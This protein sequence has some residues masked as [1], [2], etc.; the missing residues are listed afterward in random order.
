[1]SKTLRGGTFNLKFGRDPKR[2]LTE[3]GALFDRHR[4]HFL[5]VQEFSDYRNTFHASRA[6]DVVPVKGQCESG[7]IV[8]PG[9]R[10]DKQS[11]HTYGDGWITIRGGRFPAAVHNEARIGGWLYVRSVHL[12]TP[13]TWSDGRIK[14]PHDRVDDLAATAEGLRRYFQHPCWVNARLAAG[15]WNE[16]PWT[17]G[18]YAPSWVA[19]R[20]GARIAVPV[21]RA[22]HGRIDYGMVKG[23]RIVGIFKDVKIPELSDHEPVIFKVVKGK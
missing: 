8:R 13:I 17:S 5:C 20:S 7:I 10:V 1:M 11:V 2:V 15:D 9:V 16:P 21:S 14:G 6:L 18:E 19:T 22:G 4:L 23:A 3:V 12:P